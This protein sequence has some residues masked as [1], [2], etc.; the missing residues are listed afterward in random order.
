MGYEV[1]EVIVKVKREFR[2]IDFETVRVHQTPAG[3][4]KTSSRGLKITFLTSFQVFAAAAL[5]SHLENHCSEKGHP[6]LQEAAPAAKTHGVWLVK[7]WMF[8]GRAPQPSGGGISA[9]GAGVLEGS[10]G[11]C[12]AGSAHWIQLVRE[13]A[14]AA[15]MKKPRWGDVHRNCNLTGSPRKQTVDR[16]KSVPTLALVCLSVSL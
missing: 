5:G 14:S 7:T 2:G 10:G 11:H 9:P 12:V 6:S 13:G 1:N 16:G 15:L 4:V 3:L 8:G